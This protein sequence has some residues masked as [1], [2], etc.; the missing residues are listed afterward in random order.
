MRGSQAH[1]RKAICVN[2]TGGFFVLP[3][4]V[5]SGIL[6]HRSLQNSDFDRMHKIDAENVVAIKN[7]AR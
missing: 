7:K 3:K 6:L 5:K 4:E 1:G 2:R